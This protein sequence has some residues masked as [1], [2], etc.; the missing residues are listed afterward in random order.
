M[1]NMPETKTQAKQEP[2]IVIVQG[3]GITYAH[4]Y[5]SFE[6][7]KRF[8]PHDG[9]VATTVPAS[10]ALAAPEMLEFAEVALKARDW[11]EGNP[12]GALEEIETRAKVL[13][14]KVTT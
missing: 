7:S 3:E 5:E 11:F 8:T 9:F 2:C 12:E 14:A 6:D 10:Q 13:I 4:A 1:S